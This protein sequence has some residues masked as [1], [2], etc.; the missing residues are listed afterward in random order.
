MHSFLQEKKRK[1]L[2]KLF[3]ILVY[4]KVCVICRKLK[5]RFFI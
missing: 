3:E 2:K 1:S 5:I 4:V